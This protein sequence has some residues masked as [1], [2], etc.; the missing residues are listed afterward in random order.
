MT[1]TCQAAVFTAVGA[2]I[3]LRTVSTPIL[4]PGQWLVRVTCCTLCGSDLH[5]VSGARSSPTPS[6]LGHEIIGTVETLP[7]SPVCDINGQ[8]V[9]IG[10]RVTWSVA[11]A[12]G[13]CHRCDSQ[14]PQK[15]ESLFKYGHER[16]SSG[17]E[18]SGGLAQ[19]CVLQCGTAVVRLPD[20]LPDAVAC[21]ANCATATVAA[22]VRS[23]G[24]LTGRRVLVLGA[25]MLGLT[26]CAMADAAGALTVC[27]SDP[28]QQRRRRGVDFGAT[29]TTSTVASD[30]FDCVFEMSGNAAAVEAAVHA[31]GIGGRI[32][33]VGS[34]SPC[35]PAAVDPERIVRRLLMICGVHNYRPDDLVTAVNFLNQHHQRYP[36]AELVECSWPLSQVNAAFS[37]ALQ[38]RPIRVAV[39]PDE[40]FVLRRPD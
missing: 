13:H 12:C 10:D 28:D 26:T 36:F 34:V 33:L 8:P 9:R 21:P 7:E 30:D 15:C 3:E 4:K 2:D 5:T 17:R 24:S 16:F 20:E 29:E 11:A 35:R 14:L 1:R 19:F 31:A 18:L 38:H 27:L 23:A 40:Q 25:G 32:V 37:S 39:V 6:V 22:A